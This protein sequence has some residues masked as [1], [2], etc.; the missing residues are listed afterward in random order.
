MERIDDN[1][2]TEMLIHE[3]EIRYIYASDLVK[4]KVLDVGCGIGYG[5][6]V[7]ADNTE[8]ESYLGVDVSQEAIEYA[9]SRFK[10]DNVSFMNKNA[11]ELD[12]EQNSIDTV[13][14]FEVLE[15]ITDYED[16]LDK[17]EY[18]L[19]DS[20]YFIGSVPDTVF[21]DICED[22][23]GENPYHLV[24]F[25]LEKI[26]NALSRLFK[27]V[28]VFSFEITLGA[29][30]RELTIENDDE[31]INALRYSPGGIH[32]SLFFIASNSDINI[33]NKDCYYPFMSQVSYD[34]EYQIPLREAINK[35]TEMID[36]RDEAIKAIES[37]VDERDEYIKKLE[38]MYSDLK[39][40]ISKRR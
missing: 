3:H 20:G 27:R 22:T 13:I 38:K 37:L 5:S 21:D 10:R 4:G 11:L 2:L 35:Q 16:V 8:M 36:A 17:I 12:I 34:K 24:R 15:H 29:M 39:K 40:S 23:Y 30:L 32:G 6:K 26:T 33:S 9:Q 28:K 1:S 31:C 7:L 18:A 19:K 25:N 14:S